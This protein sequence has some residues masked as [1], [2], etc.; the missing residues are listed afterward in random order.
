MEITSCRLS[1]GLWQ[2]PKLPKSLTHCQSTFL[3]TEVHGLY[4]STEAINDYN[5]EQ[6]KCTKIN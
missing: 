2:K 1:I 6:N 3:Q 5:K 4:A